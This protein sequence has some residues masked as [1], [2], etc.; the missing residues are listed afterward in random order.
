MDISIVLI[1]IVVILGLFLIT[2]YN[3]LVTLRQRFCACASY[4]ETL[5]T[6][7]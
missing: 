1:V 5:G 6:N 7:F 4:I 2:T 3:R